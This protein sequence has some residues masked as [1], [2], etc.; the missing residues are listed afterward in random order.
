MS[1]PP[2]AHF[3]L[4]DTLALSQCHDGWWLYDRTYYGGMN[5]AIRAKTEREA[6]VEALTKYQERLAKLDKAHEELSAKVDAFVGQFV[7]EEEDSP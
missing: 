4:T 3:E 1:R 6:F 2:I 5:L 7:T